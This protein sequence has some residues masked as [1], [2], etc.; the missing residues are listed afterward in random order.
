M[1]EGLNSRECVY[2]CT[3]K[4]VGCMQALMYIFKY[5]VQCVEIDKLACQKNP[6]HIELLQLP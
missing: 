3:G 5:I 2:A 6:L 1:P 4:G